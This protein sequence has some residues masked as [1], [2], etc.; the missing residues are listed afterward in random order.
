MSVI[1]SAVLAASAGL[2]AAWSAQADPAPQV[3]ISDP[4]V[5]EN[6]AI[7]FVHGPSAPGP[8]PLTLQEALA[9]GTVHVIETGSVNELKIE[10]IGDADVFI[11]SGDI[12]KGG[13]QDRVLTASFALPP[14]S[15][16]VPIAA[17]CVEH[18][19]WS[20][21]GGEDAARFASSINALPSRKAK[22]A[23]KLASQAPQ[24]EP[25]QRGGYASNSTAA[26]Q[27]AMWDEVSKTQEKLASGINAPVAS[28]V[29][30]TS[31]E[32]SLE[33]DKLASQRADYLKALSDKAAAD[34]IV[35]YVFAVNGRINSADLYPSNGLFRKMW[36][37]LL[38][39]AV[40]E[41]L[42]ERAEGKAGTPPSS[43]AVKDFLAASNEGKAG[44]QQIGSLA[45][46]TTRETAESLYTEASTPAGQWLHR[47]YL[48]K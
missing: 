8:V 43:E 22:L 33:N 3:Q 44:A 48:A 26:R 42:S 40:T 27:L 39:A 2:F 20:K 31:L 29:S 18:G 16:E 36:Q 17:Y 45:K 32:L 21:R 11:Q 9:R 24:A 6:L 35:G 15:G 28:P 7:Y 12:V 30:S 1:K 14:Q 4:V 23:M 46:E 10:N 25:S 37:K 38:A 34:D 41:A 5:H 13:R 19:R 47:N